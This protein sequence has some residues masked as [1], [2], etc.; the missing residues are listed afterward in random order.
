MNLVKSYTYGEDLEERTIVTFSDEG[1]VKAVKTPF[2]IPCGVTLFAGKAGAKGDV[3]RFGRALVKTSEAVNAGDL[4]MAD[5]NGKACK[6]DL[7]ADVIK[8]EETSKIVFIIGQVEESCSGAADLW[9]MVN[10]NVITIPTQAAEETN[11]EPNEE[12]NGES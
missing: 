12:I 9:V 7:D 11:E 1:V 6:F 2:E 3:V 8:N 4:L 10:P 5:E